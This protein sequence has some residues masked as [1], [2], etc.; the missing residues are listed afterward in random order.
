MRQMENLNLPQ[1]NFNTGAQ[2][3][4]IITFSYTFSPKFYVDALRDK[5]K[6][7]GARGIIGLQRVFKVI[8]IS[9]PFYSIDFR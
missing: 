1:V 4:N 6:Q 2:L 7:R 9:Y 3:S 8:I 5:L